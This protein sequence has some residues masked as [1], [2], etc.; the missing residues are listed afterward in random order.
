MDKK[1]EKTVEKFA[2][3]AAKLNRKK[4]LLSWLFKEKYNLD[5][6]EL[7]PG[8]IKGLCPFHKEKT[9]SF[10]IY[11]EHSFYRCMSCGAIGDSNT[12]DKVSQYGQ[13]KDD[14]SD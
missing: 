8:M 1:V 5:L 6:I 4:V 10:Y 9:P 11:D 7:K 3:L 2:K 14:D 13:I 12:Y